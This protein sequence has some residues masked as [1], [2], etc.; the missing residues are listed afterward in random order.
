MGI[1]GQIRECSETREQRKYKEN[2]EYWENIQDRVNWENKKYSELTW[3]RDIE[4]LKR[5][6]IIGRER[7]YLKNIETGLGKQR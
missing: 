7:E 4:N 3:F 1:K 6:T 5:I 2:K